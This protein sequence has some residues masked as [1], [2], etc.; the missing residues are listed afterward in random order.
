MT[1]YVTIKKFSELSGYSAEAVRHKLRDG[2]W[3]E[4]SV[5]V[6]AQDGRILISINGYELWVEKGLASGQNPAAASKSASRTRASAA[7]SVSSLSPLP[8]I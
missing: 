1:N 5:W 4:N 7:T 6:K 8:L 3:A 2:T